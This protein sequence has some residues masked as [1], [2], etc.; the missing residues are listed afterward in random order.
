M[1]KFNPEEFLVLVV[2]DI[3]KNIQLV[4]EILDLVGY[5]TTF[6]TSG[7][8][9]I[10][11]VKTAKPDL[12][13]LDLMMPEMSGLEV[14]EKLKITSEYQD[15]PIIFITASNEHKYLL[16]AF[17]SGAADYITKPFNPSELLA[18]VRNHLELKHT[19]DQL[20][21]TLNELVIAKEAAVKSATLK[22]QFLANMSHEI[23]TPI[24]GVL[25][26]TELLLYTELQPQ[27]LEYLQTLKS[28]GENLLVL[29]NDILDLSK[30]EVGE[31]E[32]DDHEFEISEL[33]KN[34]SDIFAFQV[35]QKAIEFNYNIAENVPHQLRGDSFRLKQILNN[36]I[37]NALK[38]TEH[39]F[40]KI[41]V[42]LAQTNDSK[43]QLKLMFLV[44]D[45]GIGITPENQSKIFQSFT[46]VDASTT[47]KYG[48]T[49]LGLAI[50]KQLVKLMGGEIGVKS[51]LNKGSKFAFTAVFKP[52]LLVEKLP[53]NLPEKPPE[54]I[55]NYPG[56]KT[57]DFNI[58]LVED[59][60]VNQK[61]LL[62]QLERLGYEADCVNNGEEA[63][64]ALAKKGYDIVLMDCQMP[65]LDG[66]EATSKWREKEA[67]NQ[68]I[69]I[70]GLTA[71]AMEGDREKCLS[72]GMDDYLSKPVGMKQ[73]AMVIQKWLTK[74]Q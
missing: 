69:I 67:K 58:L 32:L 23:R 29:I 28:C 41:N 34:I 14:C 54:L 7:I 56:Q 16:D 13:L 43:E 57:Q 30:L 36:L 71:Y 18:R 3:P 65:V 62:K 64:E 27:Q 70:I 42:S 40:V 46:Q 8:Q 52:S 6:A 12:I 24:N 72:A 61:I 48:G 5:S 25:G 68:H 66:Y 51:E 31:I 45:T 35:Q 21:N 59:V 17:N 39:G 74:S 50:C 20:Q 1:N 26:I 33:I 22:T 38:F 44:S 47:R 55:V 9:A 63:V 15:I 2:D 73:L 11:R 37:S 19:R 60:I 53:I 49:G 10:D 4:I